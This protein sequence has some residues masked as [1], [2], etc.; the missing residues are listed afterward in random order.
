MLVKVTALDSFAHN[1]WHPARGD[2]EMLDQHEA[3]ELEAKGLVAVEHDKKKPP[4]GETDNPA[5]DLLG[6]AKAEPEH[7]NKM[8]PAPDNKAAP[9]PRKK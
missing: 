7:E 9:K 6:D 1:R 3:K 5:D 4:T 2:T 8:E